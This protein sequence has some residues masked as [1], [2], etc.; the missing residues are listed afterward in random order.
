ML[1]LDIPDASLGG[2][3]ANYSIIHVPWEHRAEVFAEFHRVL[4]PGGQL[5]LVFQVGDDR[6]HYDEVDGLAISLDCAGVRRACRRLRVRG[7]GAGISVGRAPG[8]RR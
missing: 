6:K 5:M 7:F 2:V 3:L 1:G 8:P 4:A